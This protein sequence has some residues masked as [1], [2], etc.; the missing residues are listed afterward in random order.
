MFYSTNQKSPVAI[1]I[2]KPIPRPD[3]FLSRDKGILAQ[4]QGILPGKIEIIA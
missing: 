2:G 1:F 4:E 3:R